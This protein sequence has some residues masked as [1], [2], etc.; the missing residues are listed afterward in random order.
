MYDV[1]ELET[2]YRR[3]TF[4]FYKDFEDPFF[5]ITTNMDVTDLVKKTR[6]S[7]L[8]FFAASMHSSLCAINDLEAFR[9][10]LHEGELR[11]YHTIHGG[12]TV[13]RE[14][15]TFSFSYFDFHREA[16]LFSSGMLA[17]IAK[18]KNSETFNPANDRFDLIHYS[19]LPWIS[20]TGIKH[21]Q[22]LPNKD[23]IPKLVF[24]KYFEQNDRL[25][26][27]FSVTAHH[28]LVDGLHIA[29]YFDRFQENLNAW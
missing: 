27:P 3:H 5:S 14:D 12:T 22:R 2:Y 19:T 23:S 28:A 25:L 16:A 20:F 13:L 1:I 8:N 17:A 4:N 18:E 21:A 6:S 24:G 9:L 15:E 10:R 29:R 26:L 7:D 11:R